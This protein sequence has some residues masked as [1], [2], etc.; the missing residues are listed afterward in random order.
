MTP[1]EYRAVAYRL[2]HHFAQKRLRAGKGPDSVRLAMQRAQEHL[3]V[4]RAYSADLDRMMRRGVE[5]ALA[6]KL[7]DRRYATLGSPRSGA[8]LSI[9]ARMLRTRRRAVAGDSDC[10]Q[11]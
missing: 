7:I 9:L 2:G 6:G 8:C 11:G 4:L 5:D 3:L 1:E 10:C